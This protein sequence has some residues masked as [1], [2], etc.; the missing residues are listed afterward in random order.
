MNVIVVIVNL[1]YLYSV[2]VDGVK[3]R[4]Y[5]TGLSLILTYQSCT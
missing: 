4:M 1:V 3:L 5:V 2:T